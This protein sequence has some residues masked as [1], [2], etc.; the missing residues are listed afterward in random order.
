MKILVALNAV[1]FLDKLTDCY[2]LKVTLL[3]E[4]SWLV[5]L[6]IRLKLPFYMYCDNV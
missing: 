3:H 2:L 4:I 5:S 6:L 1:E